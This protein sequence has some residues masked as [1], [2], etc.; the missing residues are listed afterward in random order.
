[1]AG[2]ITSPFFKFE[3]LRILHAAP[4]EGAE[5]GECLDA[6]HDVK[7][8]DSDSWYNAWQGA[9][10][11]S[12]AL[13]EDAAAAGDVES[14]R[15][16]LLR[17]SHY[18]RSS[19]TLLHLN[20]NDPRILSTSVKAVELF[21]RAM[22]LLDSK[23]YH[24]EIP[25]E[26]HTLPAYLYMPTDA[27]R[28]KGKIPLIVQTGG[29][30]ST[31]EELYFFVAAAARKRGYAVLTFEGPGQG[32]MI[33]KYQKHLRPDW[34]VVISK[35]LDFVCS[36]SHDHPELELDL[37]RLC[38]TGNSMGGYFALRGAVE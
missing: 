14:Q 5:I 26:D 12:Q 6:V 7:D 33:R 37:D 17:S 28:M 27:S 19:E 24:L 8:G 21:R 4:F 13:A 36:T 23:V 31:Q 9:A 38:L 15:W 2:Q 22:A 20:P 25:Y 11:R 30:D 35:V 29:Y 3:F 10:V 1:M 32:L 18:L 16:C 34:E